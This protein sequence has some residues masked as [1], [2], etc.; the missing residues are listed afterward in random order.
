MGRLALRPSWAY[1]DQLW[2]RRFGRS[3]ST[4]IAS[5]APIPHSRI[6]FAQ[7]SL[8]EFRQLARLHRSCT[9]SSLYFQELT[10]GTLIA[11]HMGASKRIR[12]GQMLRIKSTTDGETVFTVSGRIHSENLAELSNLI[13]AA[14]AGRGM[15][16]DLKELILVDRD[17]V[18]FL[19]RCESN[20][21]ELRNCSA[22]IREWI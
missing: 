18:R 1:H 6:S 12:G 22:Y 3:G 10:S 17:A 2:S 14:A 21:I 7:L 9:T 20:G 4:R 16:L 15:V 5:K 8:S 13:D 11:Q 19:K